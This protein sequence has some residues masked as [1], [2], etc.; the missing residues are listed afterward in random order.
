[1]TSEPSVSVVVPVYKSEATL[2]TLVQRLGS[3]LGARGAPFEIV[4]VN[5]GGRDRS[6]DVITKLAASSHCVR[7]I[8]LLRNYGQH[9]ALLC[10]IRTAANDVIVTIDDD[11]QNPPEEI[12]KLIAALS[13]GFDVV[14]G[15]PEKVS[16]DASRRFGSRTLRLLV[17]SAVGAELA[18][19][20][21]SFRAFPRDLREAFGHY[22][23]SFVSIDVLLTWGAAS[24]G[25]VPVRHE[26]RTAGRS[27]YTFW[28][29]LGYA[30]DVVTGFSTRPL[31]LASWI[32][33]LF[34]I[35]GI[36]VLGWV[37]G[38]YL[39]LGYSLPGFPFLASVI[40]I[41]S[42]AQLFALGII[43]EYLARIHLRTMERPYAV[44][45]E[46]TGF[47]DER[48]PKPGAVP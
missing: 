1:M 32:G 12:P 35:F 47:A 5:D 28:K 16:R 36:A 4:L 19:N 38:R 15:T 21:S 45:R 44:V 18:L 2:E 10:G 14:Y 7:G 43:G 27:T 29:L 30:I 9:N 31:R 48:S 23:G 33:F 26:P 25:F 34:T 20:M 17:A 46:T 11:L 6:W 8:R 39:W 37:V 3:V 40:A 41:F 24:Y 13:K 42:G 22:G